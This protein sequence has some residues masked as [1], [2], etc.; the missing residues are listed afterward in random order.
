MIQKLPKLDLGLDVTEEPTVTI[1]FCGETVTLQLFNPEKSD[2]NTLGL[3]TL[4][5]TDDDMRDCCCG[6][7]GKHCGLAFS[8]PCIRMRDT[9][10]CCFRDGC[11]YSSNA[12]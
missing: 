7:A 2:L 8:F 9:G 4:R 12:L 5:E 1:K 11:S 3:T 6:L 10:C